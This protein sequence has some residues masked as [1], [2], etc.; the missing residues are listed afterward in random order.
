[1]KL[2]VFWNVAPCSL[3]EIDRRFRGVYRPIALV[4][5]VVSSSETSVNIY[6]TTRPNI[7]EDSHLHDSFGCLVVY[8]RIVVFYGLYTTGLNE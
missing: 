7:P 3:I 1:V 2:A 6:Q 4:M 8:I 5:E